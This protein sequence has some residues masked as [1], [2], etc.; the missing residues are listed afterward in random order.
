MTTHPP[1]DG[2]PLSIAAAMDLAVDL[3]RRGPLVDPNPRVGAVLLDTA[4]RLLG[5]GYHR[6]SGTPH[7]EV[8]A[9]ADAA[10]RGRSAVG[11]TAVVTLE[12][13]AHTGRTGP[14]V[15]A[16]VHAGVARV[17]FAEIDPGRGSG[18]GVGVLRAAGVE[19]SRWP[20]EAAAA[21]N[22]YWRH[23]IVTGRPWV[24]W[25]LAATLDGRV[26]AAD[27]TS[28][29]ITSPEARADVHALR[30]ACGA[31]LTGTGTALA[32]DPQLTVRAVATAG[33]QAA[34]GGRPSLQPLR[35]VLGQRDLPADARLRDD[36]APTLQIRSRDPREALAAIHERGIRRVLLECGPTLAAAFLRA[37]LVDE[38]VA[39]LAPALLGSGAAVVTDLGI[40]TIAD[41]AR[42][43]V[44]AVRRVGPDVRIDVRVP[45]H[46]RSGEPVRDP[47]HAAPERPPEPDLPADPADNYPPHHPAVP[48]E[49]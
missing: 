14:C 9:L 48:Q 24:T 22:P 1:D 43:E 37:G 8:A 13:C 36:A 11:S 38:I 19:T 31:V 20:H 47:T 21:L 27:G 32:D 35:V 6:G 49:H 23:A 45:C 17:V 44:H 16:L 28:Q 42:F 12:P 34:G 18:G 25:K 46:R 30:A 33:D 4:G 29:W 7:A 39:Y 10:S 15:D 41:I 2:A 26:A 3:A 5:S 40:G